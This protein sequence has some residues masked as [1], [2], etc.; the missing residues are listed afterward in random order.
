MKDDTESNLI[1]RTVPETGKNNGRKL[2]KQK[3]E[4]LIS[5]SSSIR[6]Q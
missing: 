3:M 4:N 5:N 1:Y 2:K 6:D